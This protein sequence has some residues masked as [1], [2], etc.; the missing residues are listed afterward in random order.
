ML[1]TNLLSSTFSRHSRYELIAEILFLRLQLSI[2]ARQNAGRMRLRASDLLFFLLFARFFGRWKETHS[3]NPE[4][5]DRTRLAS[6]PVPHVLEI[7]DEA[8]EKSRTPTDLFG[9]YGTP[10]EDGL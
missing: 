1:R 9:G 5:G 6:P 2:A 7:Q 4:T 10:S 3:C 8:T